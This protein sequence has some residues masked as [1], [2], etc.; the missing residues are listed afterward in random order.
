LLQKY[1]RRY[2]LR[3]RFVRL[4]HGV[5]R[6]QATV[7][8]VLVRARL[9]RWHEHAT[10]IQHRYRGYRRTRHQRASFLAVKRAVTLIQ[11]EWREFKRRQGVVYNW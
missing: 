8:G 4:R 7:R 3:S 9:R 1:A 5:I 6:L 10:K 2:I 11:A